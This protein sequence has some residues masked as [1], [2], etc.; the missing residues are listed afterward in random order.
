VIII[1]VSVYIIVTVIMT[2]NRKIV[3][4]KMGYV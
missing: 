3:K 2:M 4:I 1:S